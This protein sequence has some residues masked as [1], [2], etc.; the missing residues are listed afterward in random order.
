MYAMVGTRPDIAYAVEVLGHFAHD[1]TQAHFVLAKKLLRYLKG[2]ASYSILYKKG[3]GVAKLE[4]YC[5]S[6]WAMSESCKSTG[7]NLFLINEGSVSWSSKLQTCVALSSTEAEYMAT[8]P[9]A[10][11]AL[12]LH[13][14]LEEL[15]QKQ[16]LPTPIFED[17]QSCIH[18]AK[19][20]IHHQRTKHI[21]IQY[22]F[23]REHIALKDLE[24][25][26]IHT[27]DM[28]ANLL[29][30]ATSKETHQRLVG[31]LVHTAN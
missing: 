28:L 18:L 2:T 17:N 25:C 9:A 29:T 15:G 14:L 11:E 20:P 30:K 22:H 19:N 1:P 4:G 24:L 21:D 8:T 3:K 6:D 13:H 26:Y 31:R 10:K 23:I 12:W 27:S 7:G 16:L 5:D